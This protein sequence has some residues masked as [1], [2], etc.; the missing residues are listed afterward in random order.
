MW[1]PVANKL[2]YTPKSWSLSIGEE[3]DINDIFVNSVPPLNSDKMEWMQFTGLKDKNGKEIYEWDIVKD[4]DGLLYQ[5]YYDN[6]MTAQFSTYPIDEE[7]PNHR[8]R[9]NNGKSRDFEIIG[10]IF[11]NREL[12]L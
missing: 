11:E 9:F 3:T 4:E 1:N 6:I 5:I 8:D 12:M 2:V 10:N 7:G